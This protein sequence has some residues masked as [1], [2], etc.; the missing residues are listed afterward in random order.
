[1]AHRKRRALGLAAEAAILLFL[2]LP[3][4]RLRLLGAIAAVGL[5]GTLGLTGFYYFAFLFALYILFLG[6]AAGA[7]IFET[8]QRWA[9][10]AWRPWF[11]IV[12]RWS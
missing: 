3:N 10:K 9:P 6:P 7:F 4:Q 5:H 2:W 11:C 8:W 12:W 1:M